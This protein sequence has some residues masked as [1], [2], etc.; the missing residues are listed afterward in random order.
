MADRSNARRVDDIRE[1]GCFIGAVYR[2][3]EQK[4]AE[5]VPGTKGA[6][7]NN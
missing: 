3:V 2:G 4:A 6:L 1:S 5:V 7:G